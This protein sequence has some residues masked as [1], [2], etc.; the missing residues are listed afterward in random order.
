MKG[1]RQKSTIQHESQPLDKLL[2]SLALTCL[3][4]GD[5]K[6]GMTYLKAAQVINPGILER[7]DSF[8]I[9]SNDLDM[10]RKLNEIVGRNLFISLQN[11][12]PQKNTAEKLQSSRTIQLEAFMSAVYQGDLQTIKMK[13]RNDPAVA[14]EIGN[15]KGKSYQIKSISALQYA[16]L[17]DDEDMIAVIKNFS[18]EEYAKQWKIQADDLESRR[19]DFHQFDTVEILD[20]LYDELNN[21]HSTDPWRQ[22]IGRIQEK[23]PAWLIYFLMRRE[24]RPSKKIEL[25][26]PVEA[27]QKELFEKWFRPYCEIDSESEKLGEDCAWVVF[28]E[29]SG[30]ST[31]ISYRSEAVRSWNNHEDTRAYAWYLCQ[32]LDNIRIRRKECQNDLPHPAH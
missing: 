11:S 9:N 5:L 8:S 16:L 29:N 6:D 30:Y 3:K 2:Q 18:G 32:I 19:P 17:V 15:I 4:E 13:I 14:Y 25:S 21:E 26:L 12:D 20:K 23:F 7:L 28:I 22:R 1:N 27:R 31:K 24:V 10:I